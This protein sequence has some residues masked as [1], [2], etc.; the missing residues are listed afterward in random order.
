M[1]E[2]LSFVGSIVAVATLAEVVV[3][4]GYQYLKAVKDCPQDVRRLIAEVNVLC[5]VLDRLGKLLTTSETDTTPVPDYEGDDAKTVSSVVSESSATLAGD[6]L[7]TPE[8]IYECQKILGHI[9]DILHQFGHS[10]NPSSL[11]DGGKLRFSGS[12]LR[13]LKAKDLKWPLSKSKTLDLIGTLE[14]HKATCTIAL[15]STGIAGVHS[16]LRET[17]ISNEYLA[18]IRVKQEEMLKLQLSQEQEYIEKALFWLTPVNPA[19]KHRA[20]ARER[21]DGTGMWLFDLPEMT[22]WLVSPNAALWIYGIPGAGKTTLST[23]VVDEVLNRTRSNSIGTAYFYV[24]HDDKDS[25]KPANVL[26]SLGSSASPPPDDELIRKLGDLS[27]HF[28]ETFIMIDG[29]DEC[30]PPFTPDRTVLIDAVARLNDVKEGSIRILIFSRDEYDIRQTLTSRDFHTVSVAATSADLRLF[31]N[32][33]LGKLDISSQA[34]KTDIVDTLVDEA[35]GMFMWIRAQVDYLQRLPND[36]EKRHALGRLPPDLP[37]TYVRIL[38]TIDSS[39]RGQTPKY[40]QRLLKWILFTAEGKIPPTFHPFSTPLS[41][42]AL[43]EVICIENDRDWPTLEV[44]PTKDRILRWLGCLVRF[45]HQTSSVQFSHFSVEEFLMMNPESLSN[46]VARHYLV[47]PEDKYYI[48]NT[49]LDYVSHSRFKNVSRNGLKQLLWDN[50]FYLHVGQRLIDYTVDTPDADTVCDLSLRRFLTTLSPD[51][52]ELWAI[53]NRWLIS[54]EESTYPEPHMPSP[55]H[56]ASATGLASQTARLLE[57]GASPA[58][59]AIFNRSLMTPLHLAIIGGYKN[60]PRIRQTILCQVVESAFPW[61][62]PIAVVTRMLKHGGA[63]MNRQLTLY[64]PDQIGD[65]SMDMVLTVTPL[66]LALF[67]GNWEVANLLLDAGVIWDASAQADTPKNQTDICSFR[68]YL[69]M[70]PGHPGYDDKIQDVVELS[71]NR[72]LK[73]VW[74]DWKS[75]NSERRTSKVR[76]PFVSQETFVWQRSEKD[77][78]DLFIDAFTNKRWKEVRDIVTNDESLDLNCFNEEGFGAIHEASSQTGDALP[79]LL[80]LGVDIDLKTRG[81][82]TALGMA[83]SNGC[84]ENVRLLLEKGSN[85][86]AQ[87]EIGSTPL[88]IAAENDQL[89]AVHILLDAGAD[90]NATTYNGWGALHMSLTNYNDHIFATLLERG[91]ESFTPDNFGTTP[92]HRAC[93]LGLEKQVEQ[94]IAL[95]KNT[96]RDIDADSLIDGTCLYIASR[97]GHTSIVKLLL[98]HGAAID[99]VGP[100]NAL[101]SALMLACAHGH[102]EA[103]EVL[104][105]HGAALEVEG[106]RFK[107]AGGTARAFRQEKVLR[108]LEEHGRKSKTLEMGIA[109]E[110]ETED[111]KDS[112][113]CVA[114]NFESGRDAI[115]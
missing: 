29:L 102:T 90:I 95:S 82:T 36:A 32:A 53:C 91:M 79:M 40:I 108:L 115:A 71:N 75:Q 18:E 34:L 8:F 105:T 31:A 83:S 112:S 68:R 22:N 30:G 26:G 42:K 88:L 1:A 3:V 50:P 5:G 27:R 11:I 94:L 93:G 66:T 84:I 87:D 64:F 114:T 20:F 78:Q 98:H 65:V 35:N 49:C 9:Q 55:L 52:Y 6:R 57:E 2:P 51:T 25:H 13:T 12:R 111:P 16:V 69:E 110:S 28:S 107:S 60:L 89:D 100:G 61:S 58:A 97:D 104:L 39:H 77:F 62:S 48:V 41:I 46:S 103:V 14:R 70:Y 99:K 47:R 7:A 54:D 24:R 59:T 15:D 63:D 106:S 80:E 38:E 4:K 86:E 92:L 21:Q 85:L 43:Y 17:K 109:C 45:N 76:V 56:F 23:L 73:Q 33:W 113:D 101:G 96:A 67:C 81:G 74:A 19:L 37:R 44:I 10:N 72:D